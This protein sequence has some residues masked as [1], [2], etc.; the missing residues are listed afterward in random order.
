MRIWLDMANSPHPVLLGPV[1]RELEARGHTVIVTTRDHAQTRDLTLS[2]WPA[3]T[4]VGGE[5]PGSRSAKAR[6]IA[7]RV[8]GL[9]RVVRDMKVDAAAS[10][11]SY[12]QI[13]AAR[14]LGVPVLTLMDYEFQPANHLSFRLARSV[15]VPSAFPSERLKLYGASVKRVARFDGF[16]EEL[17][18]DELDAVPRPI[19]IEK[20]RCV[21]VFRPPPEGALYHQQGNSPFDLVLRRAIER[22]DVRVVVLPRMAHQRRRYSEMAG[23]DVPERAVDGLALLRSADVFVG[24]GGT[25]CRE[26]ALL[27]VRAYTMF[28]GRFAAVDGD[29]VK[30]GLLRDL[31]SQ[32]HTSVDW[33]PRDSHET[34]RACQRRR[35]RG[36]ELRGWLTARVE[37]L[38]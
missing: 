23:V 30:R 14:S 16:K 21:A 19:E 4:V 1:A 27:G 8:L 36:R 13:V 20:G 12:A 38:V 31:R 22:E 18:L 15:V 6:A 24:A 26:A 33:A 35:E 25:M 29:L 3:A 28:A 5:S 11:G 10:L 2:I 17:Y 37:E 34:A 32:D 9:R 7:S